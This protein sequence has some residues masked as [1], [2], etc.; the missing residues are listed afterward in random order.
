MWTAS[1]RDVADVPALQEPMAQ[2]RAFMRAVG[3]DLGAGFASAA[4]GDAVSATVPHALAFS[5]WPSLEA[6]GLAPERIVDTLLGWVRGV[7]RDASDST[8]P[9]GDGGR[10]H[11]RTSCR[12]S[13]GR[14]GRRGD[15]LRS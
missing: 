13:G 6:E 3:D 8:V 12:L 15:L 7:E 9:G 4:D 5:T 2:G 11:L 14:D 1:Y 10:P